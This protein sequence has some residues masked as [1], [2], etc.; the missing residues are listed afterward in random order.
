MDSINLTEQERKD[1]I[2]RMKR[3]TNNILTKQVSQFL[4]RS[5]MGAQD[6]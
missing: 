5:C 1:L 3:E 4:S 6:D 2:R